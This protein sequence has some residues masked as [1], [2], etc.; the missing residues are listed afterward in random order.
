[1]TVKEAS[2][3]IDVLIDKRDI[4]IGD[5]ASEKQIAHII[6]LGGKPE[7]PMSVYKAS[8]LIDSLYQ[9]KIDE[10]ETNVKIRDRRSAERAKKRAEEKRIEEEFLNFKVKISDEDIDNII[11]QVPDYHR[12]ATPIQKESI[13]RYLGESERT[14]ALLTKLNSKQAKELIKKLEEL[15]YIQSGEAERDKLEAQREAEEEAREAEEALLE[16]ID[17]AFYIDKSNPEWEKLP[18]TAEQECFLRFKKKYSE[19]DSRG[20]ALKK[21]I[22]IRRRELKRDPLS[23]LNMGP[24]RPWAK[25]K[26]LHASLLM[27]ELMMGGFDYEGDYKWGDIDTVL[28]ELNDVYGNW[29]AETKYREFLAENSELEEPEMLRIL[30]EGY[31]KKI[32]GKKVKKTNANEASGCLSMLIIAVAPFFIFQ[33]IA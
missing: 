16:E 12:K 14:S 18:P 13:T 5:I 2:E 28:A 23:E 21:I 15:R 26:W 19:D 20:D 17:D 25:I 4:A 22:E 1:M 6:A 9:K 8:R 33:I 3:L 27:D 30:I 10:D 24:L 7:F 11:S 32:R 29:E 31:K